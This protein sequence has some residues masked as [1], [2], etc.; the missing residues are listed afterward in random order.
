MI[1]KIHKGCNSVIF[2][3]T[4]I[5]IKTLDKII[6]RISLIQKEQTFRLDKILK[7]HHKKKGATWVRKKVNLIL[8]KTINLNQK[9]TF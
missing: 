4:I 9:L 1:K 8:Y 2:D 7:K 6:K 5:V 3:A